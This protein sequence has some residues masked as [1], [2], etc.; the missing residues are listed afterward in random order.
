MMHRFFL[1][2][3]ITGT[4]K[5]FVS[6]KVWK[7]QVTLPDEFW[8]RVKNINPKDLTWKICQVLN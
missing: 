7:I 2:S 6:A 4:H 3:K 1:S 5:M 8:R